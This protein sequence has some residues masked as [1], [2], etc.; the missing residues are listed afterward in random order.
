M[1]SGD[2]NVGPVF[3]RAFQA[4]RVALRF[5]AF[6]PVL[7][8][9]YLTSTSLGALE[10]FVPA[11]AGGLPK[12]GIPGSSFR[13]STPYVRGSSPNLRVS[14]QCSGISPH[15]RGSRFQLAAWCRRSR[16][17]PVQTGR[18]SSS[19]GWPRWSWNSLAGVGCVIGSG[20]AWLVT[21]RM[22]CRCWVYAQEVQPPWSSPG[23]PVPS[24]VRFF[25][26][27]EYLVCT[28]SRSRMGETVSR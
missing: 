25:G 23:Q 15:T 14:P 11:F 1:F 18:V 4:G 16:N 27:A 24:S 3:A 7:A 2:G 19:H 21:K 12:L 6:V 13:V 17:I 26:D 5:T 8:G 9:I 22:S 28:G 10:S 20:L